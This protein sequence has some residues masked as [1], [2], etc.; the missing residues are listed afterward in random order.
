MG[1]WR[2]KVLTTVGAALTVRAVSNAL[3][4]SRGGLVITSSVL[5]RY[6]MSSSFSSATKYAGGGIAET[7]RLELL[8]T[9]GVDVNELLIRP[10]GATP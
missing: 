10:R 3:V 2:D 1:E 6:A 8:G 9:P 4:E 5:G 7:V